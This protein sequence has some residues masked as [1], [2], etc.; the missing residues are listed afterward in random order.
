VKDILLWQS[1]AA[2]ER[3]KRYLTALVALHQSTT[4]P[5]EVLSPVPRK[6]RWKNSLK[7]MM[8]TGVVYLVFATTMLA[9]ICSMEL[10]LYNDVAT[11]NQRSVEKLRRTAGQTVDFETKAK[12]ERSLRENQVY[13]RKL[14]LVHIAILAWVLGIG[15]AYPGAL[16]TFVWF[17]TIRPELILLRNGIPV[18]AAVVKQTPW[19]LWKRIEMVFTTPSGESIR[20]KELVRTSESALFQIDSPVWMLYSPSRPSRAKIYGL[21][22]ALAELVR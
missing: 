13:G 9:R 12:I 16:V 20:K 4:P 7:F 8:W 10:A 11:E 21:K 1:T 17:T 6:L 3:E 14:L 22:S 2:R 18:R 19:I 5:S 15:L